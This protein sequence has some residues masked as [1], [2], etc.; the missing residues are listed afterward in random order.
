MK[1]FF[2]I[3]L[4]LLFICC[5]KD[6]EEPINYP[7]INTWAQVD[8]IR[9]GV[10]GKNECNKKN[11]IT[12]KDD[13]TWSWLNYNGE[14]CELDARGAY[15][16]TWEEKS[17]DNYVLTSSTNESFVM[18]KDNDKIEIQEVNDNPTTWFFKK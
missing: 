7:V 11:R 18:K 13:G 4:S 15:I 5:S 3:T 17:E 2:L 8:V 16:G 12:F 1:N 10:S 6:S 9:N 14:K